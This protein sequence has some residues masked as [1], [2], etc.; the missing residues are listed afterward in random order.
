MRGTSL[1]FVSAGLLLIIFTPAVTQQQRAIEEFRME[2]G[3]GSS[4]LIDDSTRLS[5]GQFTY[6]FQSCQ[7]QVTAHRLL[8]SGGANRPRNEFWNDL[9]RGAVFT[10]GVDLHAS[11]MLLH[12]CMN[13]SAD[14]IVYSRDSL[15]IQ[16][17]GHA[18][19]VV[20]DLSVSSSRVN[21]FL[22]KLTNSPF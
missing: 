16:L 5:I 2:S 19:V 6:T 9:V 10:D 3:T 17:R 20:D 22:K 15:S 13:L 18:K 8:L 11:W 14:S 7:T 21:L 1:A 4:F 12:G